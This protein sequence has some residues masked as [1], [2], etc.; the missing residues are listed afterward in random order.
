LEDV[1]AVGKLFVN[2]TVSGSGPVADLIVEA[3][4]SEDPRMVYPCALM[5][6]LRKEKNHVF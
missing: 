2:V 1:R 4:L 5:R 3:V 6:E